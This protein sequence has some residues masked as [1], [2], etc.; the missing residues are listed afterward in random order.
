MDP[1]A[2]KPEERKKAARPAL[3]EKQRRDAR[4]A[5]Q[6]RRR[7]K[8]IEGNPL[9][10]GMRAV[11]FEVQRTASFVGAALLAALAALGP[12]F[13]SAGM[14]L[15]S[16]LERFGRGLK[17]L[18][19]LFGRLLA[20]LGRLVGTLDRIITPFRALILVTALAAVVLGV[21]QYKGL[22]EI[23]IGQVGYAGIEDLARAPA[24]DRTTPAGVHTQILVPIALIALAA[25][26]LLALG[27]RRA[28]TARLGRFRRLAA[29]VLVAI[30]LLTLAVSLLVDLPAAT[31]STEAALAYAD[32]QARLLA[33]FWLQLA[34]GATLAVGGIALLAEPTARPA[35]RR[36]REDHAMRTTDGSSMA[37][38]RAINGGS[39]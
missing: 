37:G 13:S 9:S 25:V 5:R 23:E 30:G 11:G 36:Q 7:R 27:S 10:K 6:N 29:M 32:V 3:T 34:A 19:R 15:V 33:G 24:I 20:A 4:E 8:P 28:F 22:G 1:E 38:S 39:A 2:P 21:S 18:G 26:S 16:L 35:R 17:S 31:D 12:V 14:G